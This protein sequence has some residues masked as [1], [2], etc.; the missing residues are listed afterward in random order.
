MKMIYRR[1]KPLISIGFK[2]LA[3]AFIAFFLLTVAYVDF[4]EA[5]LA[6]SIFNFLKPILNFS[7]LT[8]DVLNNL[9][10][11]FTDKIRLAEENK[12]LRE[13]ANDLKGRLESLEGIKKENK[14][15]RE[16]LG[17]IP[18]EKILANVILLSP[19]I[20]YDSFILD[21]GREDGVKAGMSVV[22]SGDVFLGY[23]NEAYDK[24]SRV[25][26]ISYFNQ[27]NNGFLENS[28]TPITIT[29][30]GG[31]MMKF[32]LPREA[33]VQ[34][35]ERVLTMASAPRLIGF[36]E[37]IEK[38]STNPLQNIILRIPLNIRNLRITLI[39]K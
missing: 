26:L 28:G 3:S 34:I 6:N 13:T 18:E 10:F 14:E 36:V 2:M 12:N 21:M 7:I 24:T 39:I 19:E 29:G 33:S 8:K 1:N 5:A 35:G 27:E 37:K 38:S 4:L 17:R 23:I 9:T 16:I 25:A 30:M 22:S 15:L 31:E 20:G 11:I 32:S